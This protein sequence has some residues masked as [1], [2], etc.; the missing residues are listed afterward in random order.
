MGRRTAYSGTRIGAEMDSALA[1]LSKWQQ[2]S[3]AVM[4]PDAMS[5][6]KVIETLFPASACDIARAASGVVVDP[7]HTVHYDFGGLGSGMVG[8]FPKVAL[9]ID[10]ENTPYLAIKPD[11]LAIDV[12]QP[13]A[14]VKQHILA[15]YRIYRQFEEVK[16]V[17]K[18]LNMHATIG[19][20]RTYFPAVMKLCPNTFGSMLNPP[21]FYHNPDGISLWLQALRAAGNTVAAA[22]MLPLHAATRPRNAMRLT[23]SPEKI[24][25]GDGDTTASY[26]TEQIFFNI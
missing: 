12:E 19:A 20:I 9:S 10:F 23:F 25:V 16:G 26:T 21:N 13:F 2:W 8:D 7:Y 4:V 24:T 18:W 1:L 22:Q 5:A 3:A 17:L 14:P 15:I 6:A 11:K